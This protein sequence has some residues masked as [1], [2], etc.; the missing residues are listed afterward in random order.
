MSIFRL[1]YS[2]TP[3]IKDTNGKV[4]PNSI[5]SLEK[6]KIG[7]INQYLLIRG[8]D[9]N[10][11]VLLFLHGGP[12]S[13]EMGI[14]NLFQ[15]RAEEFFTIVHWDQRGAGKSYSK[16]ITEE[17]LNIEQFISDTHELI[18]LLR[19]RFNKE[20]IYLLGHSWGTVL[21][22]LVVQRY[23]ELFH[24]YIG[25]GQVINIIENE[26]ISFQYTLDAAKK[27][28]NKKVINKLESLE[29]PYVGDLKALRFQRKWLAKYGG[30]LHNEK[31][32]MA[33]MKKM[34]VSPEYSLKDLPKFIKGMIKSL[35]VMWGQLTEI[36]FLEQVPELKIPIFFFVGRYDY[37]VPFEL[38]EIFYKKLKAPKKFLIW[39]EN[40]G[41]FPNFEEP[42][43]FQEALISE[44]LQEIRGK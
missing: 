21:G 32:I 20:K 31:S 33:V 2:K 43:K 25:M 10:N 39:F 3:K 5:T 23:P 4:L 44:V 41:H 13:P 18:H 22:I 29:P 1:F 28:G 17:T 26:K 8:H 38:V 15:R 7:D 36:N 35:K 37:Q 40:S 34:L 11:P 27:A 9:V 6:V 42:D 12:G 30:A 16:K 19:K 14:A 24:A